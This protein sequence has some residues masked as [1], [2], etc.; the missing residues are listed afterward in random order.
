MHSVISHSSPFTCAPALVCCAQIGLSL[1]DIGAEGAKPLADALRVNAS[2]TVTD[3]RYNNLD[4]ESA[5]ML[6]NIAKA[7]PTFHRS[8]SAAASQAAECACGSA[9]RA[10][11][12][13]RRQPSSVARRVGMPMVTYAFLVSHG[14]ASTTWT[15]IVTA[16]YVSASASVWNV[17][18]LPQPT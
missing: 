12:P 9:A 11:L 15:S 10:L 14:R 3:M 8:C 7:A 16:N 2:L 17:W 18:P 5:T 13:V 1:N 6:A 4:T